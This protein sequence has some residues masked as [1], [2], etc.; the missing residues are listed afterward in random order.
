M[1]TA[2][3]YGTLFLLSSTNAI[4]NIVAIIWQ[5]VS[6]NHMPELTDC[7]VAVQTIVKG[8]HKIRGRPHELNSSNHGW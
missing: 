5:A 2:G 3:R 7:E 1:P 6:T 8:A 4:I